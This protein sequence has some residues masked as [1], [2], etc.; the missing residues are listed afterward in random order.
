MAS[1]IH[2]WSASGK[3]SGSIDL[4]QCFCMVDTLLK[5]LNSSQFVLRIH[6]GR[7]NL[8][9][10]GRQCWERQRDRGREKACKAFWDLG[11]EVEKLTLSMLCCFKANNEASLVSEFWVRLYFSL[12]VSFT[13]IMDKEDHERV[14]TLFPQATTCYKHCHY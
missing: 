2:L 7:W 5:W 13:K 3:I 12:E 6:Q 1:I 14:G 9:F 8:S 4:T 10:W 11:L